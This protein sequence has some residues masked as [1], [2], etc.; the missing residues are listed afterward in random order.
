MLSPRSSS[1]RAIVS[2]NVT[3]IVLVLSAVALW[4]FV[5]ARPSHTLPN[6]SAITLQAAPVVGDASSPVQLVYF[7]RSDCS[8]CKQMSPNVRRLVQE[9]GDVVHARYVQITTDGTS[10]GPIAT[11]CADRTGATRGGAFDACITDPVVR[12]AVEAD[13]AT[14]KRLGVS[15]VPAVIIGGYSAIGF[16]PY[17]SLDS[18]YAAAVAR[19]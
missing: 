16:V 8:W 2:S 11:T 6:G 1:V 4:A 19:R 10:E 14:A 15:S 12:T 13:L 7:Y 18:L 5:E 17:A 9:H 3:T